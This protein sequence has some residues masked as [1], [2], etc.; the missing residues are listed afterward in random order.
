MDSS[1]SVKV[2]VRIKPLGPLESIEDAQHCINT[3]P[4]VAQVNEHISVASVH[5]NFLVEH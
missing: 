1:T 5:V 2:A 4:G 3:V